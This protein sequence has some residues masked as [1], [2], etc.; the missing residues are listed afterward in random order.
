MCLLCEV[1]VALFFEIM[2]AP[3]CDDTN[4]NAGY[5]VQCTWDIGA[6]YTVTA[7]LFWMCTALV[8][9]VYRPESSSLSSLPSPN[10]TTTDNN[11]RSR[12]TTT[13]P[14]HHHQQQHPTSST[15]TEAFPNDDDGGV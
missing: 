11:V 5:N 12:S 14:N 9:A 10:D 7:V 8:F 2:G 1:V 3:I 6:Y 15:S 13:T 4:N